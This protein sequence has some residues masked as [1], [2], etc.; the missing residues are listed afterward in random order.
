M[1]SVPGAFVLSDVLGRKECQELIET[2]EAMGYRPDVPI[3]SELDERAHNVVLMA[4][5][6]QN[7]QLRQDFTCMPWPLSKAL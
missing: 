5:E 6:Q 7:Q 4:N 1:V 2:T 3:S